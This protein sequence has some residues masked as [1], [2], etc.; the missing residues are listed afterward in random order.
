MY[1][2]KNKT[3]KKQSDEEWNRSIRK[4]ISGETWNK[5][6]CLAKISSS[7]CQTKRKR[8]DKCNKKWNN[9]KAVQISK[10]LLF[11]FLNEVGTMKWIK[12]NKSYLISFSIFSLKI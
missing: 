12:Q 3:K 1:T 6:K 2:H 8:I 5:I 11:F 7:K 4:Q 9:K 10:E